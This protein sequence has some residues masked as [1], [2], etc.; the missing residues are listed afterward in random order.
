ME[1]LRTTIVKTLAQVS[2]VASALLVT[3]ASFAAP[4]KV[5]V[6]PAASSIDWKGSKVT[7]SEHNGTVAIKEGEVTLD[8]TKLVA[9]K[10]LIDMNSIVNSDLTDKSYNQKLVTHLK[11]DDFFDV[12]KYP[13]STLTIKDSELQKDGTYKVKADLQ[14][15]GETHPVVFNATVAPTGK[16]AR[17]ELTI[18]RTDWNVRYG[19]GKF[20][21]NLGDKMIS[22]KIELKI[23]LAFES[24]V[25]VAKK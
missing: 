24:P 12:A 23:K 22:D 14:I 1:M 11:S 18:D 16:E 20:F 21:K 6:D 8:G 9:G 15:K 3:S 25:T 7:G 17:T 2:L 19:S 10:I 5:K 13:V 4:N